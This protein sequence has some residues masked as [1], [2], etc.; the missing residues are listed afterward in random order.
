MA[1]LAAVN[2]L[3]CVEPGAD[4]TP[5]AW[6]GVEREAWSELGGSVSPPLQVQARAVTF[7][8]VPLTT[9]VN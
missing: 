8:L 4:G 1:G 3:L 5:G 6:T 7:N 2:H 9:H